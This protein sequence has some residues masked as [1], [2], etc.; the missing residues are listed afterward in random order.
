MLQTNS[1]TS[2]E[3]KN[4][5]TQARSRSPPQSTA[6]KNQINLMSQ[7]LHGHLCLSY[8]SPPPTPARDE[9]QAKEDSVRGAQSVTFSLIAA[10]RSSPEALLTPHSTHII[11]PP[12]PATCSN[13]HVARSGSLPSP[14]TFPAFL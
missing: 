1:A 8:R 7:W 11:P 6:S 4:S 5:P 12:N 13:R 3:V 2:A 14:S 10:Y 9:I